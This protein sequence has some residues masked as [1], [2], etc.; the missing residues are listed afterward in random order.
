LKWQLRAVGFFIFADAE[1]IDD[2]RQVG[3]VLASNAVL[4]AQ[5]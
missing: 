5:R 4:R 3:E 2:M 1:K